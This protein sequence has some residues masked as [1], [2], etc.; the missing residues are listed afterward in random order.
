M[1]EKSG[2]RLWVEKII[3]TVS[4]SKISKWLQT[5]LRLLTKSKAGLW[6]RRNSRLFFLVLLAVVTLV[7]GVLGFSRQN[8]C[9][10]FWDNLYLTLQLFVLQS[11]A[12]LENF[13]WML[14]VARFSGAIFSVLAAIQLVA[15]LFYNQ[16][17][18]LR[19]KV[20]YRKHV[21]ICG[22][23]GIGPIL[24]ERYLSEGK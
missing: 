24:A 8:P 14:Q 23:G 11:G 12:Y 21:I 22:L 13:N 15:T 2:L 5:T 4:G 7:L 16:Y 10:S 19:I 18:L 1:K 3:K 6:F 9:G 20:A 17:Q